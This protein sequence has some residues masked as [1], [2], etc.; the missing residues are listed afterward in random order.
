V[1]RAVFLVLL[2]GVGCVERKLVIK[3]DPEDALVFVDGNEIALVES[4]TIYRYDHY[5]IHRV[6][7]RKPGFEVKEQ[8]VTLDPPWYQVFPI[9]VVFDILWPAKIE[10]S[11]EVYVKLEP[12]LDLSVKKESGDALIERANAFSADAKKP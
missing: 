2:L 4:Q 9:D 5:G 11:R 8:L 1:K 10:D 12:R 7:V 6:L 3:P